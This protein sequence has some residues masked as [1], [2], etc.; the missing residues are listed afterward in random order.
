MSNGAFGCASGGS[1]SW[2]ARNRGKNRAKGVP[3]SGPRAA[4][5]GGWPPKRACGAQPLRF[6]HAKDKRYWIE[7]S[8]GNAVCGRL[9]TGSLAAA[10]D[11][12]PVSFPR[13][14]CRRRRGGTSSLSVLP[15]TGSR[16]S[17]SRS[18]SQAATADCLPSA[19]RREKSRHAGGIPKGKALWL[20][21]H[22]SGRAEVC[23]RR[24]QRDLD[25][26]RFIS[27]HPG[28]V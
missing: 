9:A 19:R 4:L 18:R 22:T 12:H 28:S 2:P 11:A 3:I 14:G 7:R 10:V 16:L 17:H 5:P 26:L 27:A 8:T 21:L 23:P 15:E 24:E 20:L 13:S 6:S 1:I 25:K